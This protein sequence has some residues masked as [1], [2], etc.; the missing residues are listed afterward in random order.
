MRSWSISRIHVMF[1]LSDLGIG[2]EVHDAITGHNQATSSGRK[3]YVGIGLKV[4]FDAISKLDLS[5][6]E[7]R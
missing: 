6:L 4:K 7:Q 5:W 1:M 2:E 3:N